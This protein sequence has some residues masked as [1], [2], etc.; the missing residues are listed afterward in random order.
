MGPEFRYTTRSERALSIVLACCLLG[1]ACSGPA[2]PVI[3]PL[4][5]T[6]SCPAPVMVSSASGQPVVAV[7]TAPNVSGGTRPMTTTCTPQSGSAFPVGSTTVSCTTTDADHQSASCQFVV[8]VV[9]SPRLTVTSFL[10]F[11]DSITAGEIASA[12]GSLTSLDPSLAYPAQLQSALRQRNASQAIVVVNDGLTG[13]TAAAGAVRLPGELGRYHPNVLL[14]LEGINDIHGSV[15]PSGIPPAIM[16]LQTMIEEARG[17]GAQVI[18]GTLLP[19]NPGALL[20]GTISLIVPFNAQLVPMATSSGAFVVDLH[21]AFLADM[22]DWIGPD[23]LHPTEAGY[24]ELAQLF[25][26][27]IQADFGTPNR[28]RR[29]DRSALSSR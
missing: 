21:S 26:T 6:L 8:M 29:F 4:P 24:Q 27:A 15:G 17:S 18:I 7:Y 23:G 25:L 20:P 16:A 9:E 13:E 22:P 5:L 10:A 1:G 3:D 28:A 19:A 12:D 14:L 2:G 11:G